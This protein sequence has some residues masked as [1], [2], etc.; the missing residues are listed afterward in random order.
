M[1]R[2]CTE[3]NVQRMILPASHWLHVNVLLN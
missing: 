3:I 2:H 1:E